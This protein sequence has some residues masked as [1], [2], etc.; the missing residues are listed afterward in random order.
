MADTFNVNGVIIPKPTHFK[1]KASDISKSFPKLGEENYARAGQN[2]FVAAIKAEIKESGYQASRGPRPWCEGEIKDGE[3]RSSSP[4]DGSGRLMG[5]KLNVDE[6]PDLFSKTTVDIDVY[7]PLTEEQRQA[8]VQRAVR[9]TAAFTEKDYYKLSMNRWRSHP[10]E[11]QLDHLKGMGVEFAMMF[12]KPA[13]ETALER[14]K[15]SKGETVLVKLKEGVTSDDLW[16]KGK[17][18]QKQGPVQ[19]GSYLAQAHPR[20]VQAFFDGFGDDKEHSISYRELIETVKQW[21]EDKKRYPQFSA[22]PAS[23]EQL[24]AASDPALGEKAIDSQLVKGVLGARLASGKPT[25]GGRNAGKGRMDQK[26]AEALATTLG[27]ISED[28]PIL[29]HRHERTAGYTSEAGLRDLETLFRC[30]KALRDA[31]LTPLSKFLEDSKAPEDV[32]LVLKQVLDNQ[33]QAKQAIARTFATAAAEAEA[34][35]K[36]IVEAEAK[37]NEAK[38]A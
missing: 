37:K 1:L 10:G 35:R 6:A 27:A 38:K 16:G 15:N 34:Q 29:L 17:G 3:L 14:V 8:L 23:F 28:G 30:N 5:L 32:L 19:V 11:S 33:R 24:L 13:P 36:A 9:S 31:D 7:P 22:P 4:G 26:A 21:E 18:G 25:Q 12:F 2:P 20:A